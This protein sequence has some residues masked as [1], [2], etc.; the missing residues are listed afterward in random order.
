MYVYVYIYNIYVYIFILYMY[1]YIL[2]K[3]TSLIFITLY[4]KTKEKCDNYIRNEKVATSSITVLAHFFTGFSMT[5]IIIQGRFSKILLY[6][7]VD[8]R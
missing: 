1:I 5:A 2:K 7:T 8:K 4:Y 6:E 3:Y